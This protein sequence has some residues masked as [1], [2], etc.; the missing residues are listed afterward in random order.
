MRLFVNQAPQ[1]QTNREY[2]EP[3][4]ISIS[5]LCIFGIMQNRDIHNREIHLAVMDL[6]NCGLV[7]YTY[8]ACEYNGYHAAKG[9]I[10]VYWGPNDPRNLS[11][12]LKGD[13]QTNIRAEIQA[14][15]R[16]L[17]QAQE[18]WIREITIIMD[19]SISNRLCDQMVG[20]LAT[21][22]MEKI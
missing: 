13:K 4:E 7:V 21:K 8:G 15:V 5:R 19:V 10:G 2:A 14:A 3:R 17:Q 22:W 9:G 16:A 18:Q 11:E 6:A 12:A 1:A 20:W